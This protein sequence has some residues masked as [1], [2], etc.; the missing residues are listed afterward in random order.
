[1]EKLFASGSVLTSLPAAQAIVADC[2]EF[3]QDGRTFSIAQIEEL[4]FDQFW[5]HKGE[6]SAALEKYRAEKNY[7]FSVLLITDVARNT[8]LLLVAGPPSFLRSIDYPAVEPCIFELKDVVSR[9]KQLLPYLTICLRKAP[10]KRS[11]E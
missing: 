9:K 7:F 8:S 5:R 11:Y 1:I 6:V 4:G 10:T 3:E 2:K